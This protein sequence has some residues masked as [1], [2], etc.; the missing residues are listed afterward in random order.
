MSQEVTLIVGIDVHK[1]THAAALIDDRGA[2]V[3]ALT[4]TNGPKGYRQ[5]IDW[6]VDR[7]AAARGDRR[8]K[9]W[10]L[11]TLPGRRAGRRGL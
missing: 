8:R 5:L 2:L 1:Q 4:I 3:G 9:P 10:Q 6:L 7:D 11:R